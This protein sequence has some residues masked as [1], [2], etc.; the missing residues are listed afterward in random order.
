MAILAF[1]KEANLRK[2]TWAEER[3]L[4]ESHGEY[5]KPNE[6]EKIDLRDLARE[7]PAPLGSYM[8]TDWGDLYARAMTEPK[9][10]SDAER[11]T[12][13]RTA[14]RR[15]RGGERAPGDSPSRV[16]NAQRDR[17]HSQDSRLGWL[18]NADPRTCCS[19]RQ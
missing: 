17:A 6:A 13:A 8:G 15:G 16:R 3:L 1:M 5:G 4:S 9:T 11:K 12:R 14:I 10:L 19:H 7:W 18:E 2:L